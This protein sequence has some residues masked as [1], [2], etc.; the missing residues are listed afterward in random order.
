MIL[1]TGST[2]IVGTRLTFDLLNKGEKV[3]AMKRP[4][5]DTEFVRRVFRFYDAERGEELLD[6]IEW[7]DGDI[8]DLDSLEEAMR[9][10]HTVYHTAALVSYA[11]SDRQ[12]LAIINGDGT[13]N[14]VNQAVAS[15][16][17]RFCHVSSVAA[18]GSTDDGSPI[19]ESTPRNTMDAR[20]FYGITKYIAEREV[21]RASAESAL[22]M[23]IVNPSIILGPARSDQ[24]SGM[25]FSTLRKGLAYYPPG[26]TGIVDVRDVSRMAIELAESDVR[27]ERFLL[28]SENITY[29]K[30]LELSAEV[31]GHAK[32]KIRVGFGALEAAWVASGIVSAISGNRAKIT[33]ETARSATRNTRYNSEKVRETLNTGF[34][35][36]EECLKY[37]APFYRSSGKG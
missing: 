20:S 17:E 28:N 24:S 1:V 13:A 27:S 12:K 5:S 2:G 15:D 14:V 7:V 16:V 19:D 25:L 9:G 31:F 4:D 26:C 34:I 8:L 3:R 29:R 10:V 11:G 21:W 22:S 6:H 23:V 30:L 18:L 35:T 32:P 37:F 36:V 33:R